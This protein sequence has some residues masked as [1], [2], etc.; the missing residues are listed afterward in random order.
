MKVPRHGVKTYHEFCSTSPQDPFTSLCI[1]VTSSYSPFD[2]H[3]LLQLCNLHVRDVNESLLHVSF[4]LCYDVVPPRDKIRFLPPRS[5]R[6]SRG[7]YVVFLHDVLKL[8]HGVL[9]GPRYG[10]WLGIELG[11][12]GSLGSRGHFRKGLHRIRHL[13][14]HR[15]LLS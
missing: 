10:Y 3:V 4:T 11:L 1:Y 13:Q 14:D 12:V 15:K 9:L 6:L 8:L 5:L 2:T 7:G